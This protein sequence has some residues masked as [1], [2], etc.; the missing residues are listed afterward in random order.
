MTI[1][2]TEIAAGMAAALHGLA[3]GLWALLGNAEPWVLALICIFCG[4]WMVQ[5]LDRLT[6][7]AVFG[8]LRL[9][10]CLWLLGFSGRCVF[11]GCGIRIKAR[12]RLCHSH[13][14]AASRYAWEHRDGW[15][16]KDRQSDAFYVYILELDGGEGLYAG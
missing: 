14:L 9:L 13:F 8:W 7:V 1:E 11:P 3:H 10:R 12:Y 5:F 6:Q 15:A 2:W 16:R 4:A